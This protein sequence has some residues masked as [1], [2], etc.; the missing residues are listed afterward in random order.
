M[1]LIEKQTTT[2][3]GRLR[4]LRRQK[5]LSLSELARQ[6]K[7]AKSNLSKYENDLRIPGGVILKKL[8]DYF[9]INSDWILGRDSNISID[10]T[11]NSNNNNIFMHNNNIKEILLLIIKTLEQ[12]GIIRKF[13]NGYYFEFA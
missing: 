1:K 10:N 6:T 12:K 13:N 3:G 2:I 7:I 5:G 8:S 9:C 11:N 4:F